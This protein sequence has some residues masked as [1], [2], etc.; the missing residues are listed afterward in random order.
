MYTITDKYP[1]PFEINPETVVD[2]RATKA[3][4]HYDYF[5]CLLPNQNHLY[6]HYY[7]Q[8]LSFRLKGNLKTV[9][10]DRATKALKLFGYLP[11]EQIDLHVMV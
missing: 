4:R 8:V 5:G 3:R 9:V 10:N 6:V 1:L 2:D 11:F 7:R